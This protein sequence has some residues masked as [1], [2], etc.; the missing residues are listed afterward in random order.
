MSDNDQA[1]P[2]YKFV[3]SH[4]QMMAVGGMIL[5][6][7]FAAKAMQVLIPKL[8]NDDFDLNNEDVAFESYQMADAMLKE[9]NK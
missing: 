1:F 9:R 3:E 7:Y 8:I 6:D 5:R 4:G 2:S